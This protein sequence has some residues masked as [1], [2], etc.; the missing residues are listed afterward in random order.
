[1]IALPWKQGSV[2]ASPA[3]VLVSATRTEFRH[4]RDLLR[5]VVAGST[6]RR[7]WPRT[8]GA[9]GIWVA[10]EPVHRRSWTLTAWSTER[11]LR[12]FVHSPQHRA[13]TRRYRELVTVSSTTWCANPFTLPEAL[14]EARQRLDPNAEDGT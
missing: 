13:I 8:E 11:D 7:A 2:R 10:V 6:L 4:R 14:E 5:A 9:I 1:M 12:R 3:T